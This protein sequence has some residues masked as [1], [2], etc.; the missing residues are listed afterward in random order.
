MIKER[1]NLHTHVHMGCLSAA[2]QQPCKRQGSSLT[3]ARNDAADHT[4][5]RVGDLPNL[6]QGHTIN[7][8]VELPARI[9][10]QW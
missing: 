3:A 7:T 8:H 2:V 10:V 1:R 9:N 5:I 4:I 6:K